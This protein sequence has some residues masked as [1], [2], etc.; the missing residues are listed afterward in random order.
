MFWWIIWFLDLLWVNFADR[1][2]RALEEADRNKAA[3][4]KAKESTKVRFLE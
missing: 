3:L 2:N 1:L 4:Q